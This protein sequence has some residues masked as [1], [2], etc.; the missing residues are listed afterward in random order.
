MATL[1]ARRVKLL[2][3]GLFEPELKQ[4]L[5]YLPH[6]IGVVTSPSGAVVRDILHRLRD[7]FPR[8]VLI[9][10]AAVQGRACAAE[11]AAAIVGFNALEK[12]AAIPRP[13]VLIVARGGGS[14]E[15][16][17]G[18]NEEIVVRAASES[19]IP[20][21]SA[22]GHETDTTLLDFAADRRAP[23][24]TAAAEMAV[25]VRQEVQAALDTLGA[26]KARSLSNGQ[27]RRGQNLRNLA[28]ALP[29]IEVLIDPAT[30]CFDL[31][32]TRLAGALEAMVA[33]KRGRFDPVSALLR[34]NSLQNMTRRL[35]ER[36]RD[37][38]RT[39]DMA[40]SRRLERTT[41][42]TQALLARLDPA[43]ARIMGQSARDLAR[44]RDD[45]T[46][47]F[48]RLEA[49]LGAYFSA[50]AAA[51]ASLERMRQ[52]LGCDQTLRRG[53]AVVR[54]DQGLVTSKTQVHSATGLEIEFYDGRLALGA[55][56]VSPPKPRKPQAPP[57]QG[58]LF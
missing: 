11:V 14:I 32:S 57:D 28:R 31:W 37:N 41:D 48:A 45:L 34:P 35:S 58:Q 33:R 4:N 39:L 12:G 2:A 13:D 47:K 1:E 51:L 56:K 16:L 27:E 5:P 40:H 49:A 54:S 29:R 24:P 53:F 26:R 9:W 10:P 50:H 15:D 18:F 55:P 43:L 8:H 7:R 19:A 38:S 36:L 3:E 44:G 25:P 17:W 42:R 23:T 20:L 22:V 46:Q 21:I 52:T 6:V 30:Q